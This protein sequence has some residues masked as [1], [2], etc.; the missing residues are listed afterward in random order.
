MVS[1]GYVSFGGS[2]LSGGGGGG[3]WYLQLGPSAHVDVPN[4]IFFV[5]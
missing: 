5:H 2:L 3:G 1:R 4:L